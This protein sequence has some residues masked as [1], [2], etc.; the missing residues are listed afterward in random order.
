MTRLEALQ[1]LGLKEGFNPEQLKS[2][3]R[4]HAKEVHP[5]KGGDNAKFIRLKKAYDLLS[6]RRI[7]SGFRVVVYGGCSV[8]STSTTT[9]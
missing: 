1:I 5:D 8:Y 7:S 4:S 6:Q 2:A 3:Y 9:W